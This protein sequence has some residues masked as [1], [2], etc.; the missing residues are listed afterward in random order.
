M[1]FV[2]DENLEQQIVDAL[3]AANHDV[4]FIAETYPSVGDEKVLEIAHQSN[5]IVITNDKDF[6]ELIFRQRKNNHGVI[7]VRFYGLTNDEKAKLTLDC[8]NNFKNDI[9]FN[10]IVITKESVRIRKLKII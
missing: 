6:G 9:E 4:L 10:Y 2:A 1:K 8:I 3:R 7:L 5:A